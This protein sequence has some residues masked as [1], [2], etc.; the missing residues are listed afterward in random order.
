M[1]NYYRRLCE[2][3]FHN[4]VSTGTAARTPGGGAAAAGPGR[5]ATPPCLLRCLSRGLRGMTSTNGMF[6]IVYGPADV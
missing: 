1:Q 4:Y 6:A 2:G 3:V 5:T